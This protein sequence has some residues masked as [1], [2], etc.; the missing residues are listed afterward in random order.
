MRILVSKQGRIP[1]FHASNRLFQEIPQSSSS[2]SFRWSEWWVN[3][4]AFY[5]VVVIQ[6]KH[7]ASSQQMN[8]P[9]VWSLN[10]DGSLQWTSLPE[11]LMME[12]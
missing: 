7:S 6:S 8:N 3:S 11:V 4:H 5:G 10:P 9:I 2:G 1:N 12:T